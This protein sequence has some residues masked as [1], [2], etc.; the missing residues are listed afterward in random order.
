MRTI[1]GL[2]Y[3]ELEKYLLNLTDIDVV[4]CA[5]DRESL[6]REC[7]S[8]RPDLII[9]SN[10]LQGCLT[11]EDLITELS[12]LNNSGIIFLYG[13]EDESAAGFCSF[14]EVKGILDYYVGGS[15]TSDE[16]D[17][18]IF[19][20]MERSKGIGAVAQSAK[21]GEKLK[22]PLLKN[23]FLR[24]KPQRWQSL[25]KRG[26]SGKG[27]FSRLVVCI[28]SDHATGKSHTAWNLSKCIAGRR[29]RTSL[30]NLDKGYSA[31]IY[32]GI[33]DIYDGLLDYAIENNEYKGILD[34]CYKSAGL[35][36]IAGKLGD[37]E[38]IKPEAFG[39]LLQQVR[40]KSE[41]IIIDTKS[42]LGPITKAALNS[43][44]LDILVFDC[45]LMHYN[46]N[47]QMLSRMKDD[48]SPEKTIAIINNCD[49]SSSS[50]KYIHNQ[51]KKLEYSFKCILPV[52]SCGAV[53]HELMCTDKSPFQINNAKTKS[54]IFDLEKLAE[55]L[56]I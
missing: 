19:S 8:H 45:D 24:E 23:I 54:F 18:L 4:C 46:M 1:I 14:L 10:A 50:Y 42:S 21:I 55:E 22:K 33:D 53:S 34:G 3:T 9:V 40:L 38:D 32:F 30:I 49:K 35:N 26:T 41:V 17:E 31:N 48:F 39:R 15:I 12:D 11:M 51:L 6:L 36:V 56:S 29:Y 20:F 27:R 2:C 37:E 7:Q 5:Y 52:S 13:E 47:I 16:L 25:G 28:Y 43:S 44:D